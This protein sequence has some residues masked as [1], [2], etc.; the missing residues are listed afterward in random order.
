[1]QQMPHLNQTIDASNTTYKPETT[2]APP[3]GRLC[4]R[5]QKHH[6]AHMNYRQQR[7]HT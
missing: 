7:Q 4:H 3:P 1:M 2:H 6:L 5:P